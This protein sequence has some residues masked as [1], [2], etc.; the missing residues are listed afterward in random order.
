LYG[1]EAGITQYVYIKQSVVTDRRYVMAAPS[2]TCPEFGDSWRIWRL[3]LLA[4]YSIQFAAIAFEKLF[5]LPVLRSHHTYSD[6]GVVSIASNCSPNL[7]CWLSALLFNPF[8]QAEFLDLELH[9]AAIHAHE[10]FTCHED[11]YLADN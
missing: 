3:R 9:K 4:S 8:A 5:S 2:K 6:H 11:K 1:S 7:H 10:R